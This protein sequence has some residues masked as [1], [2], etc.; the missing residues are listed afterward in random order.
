PSP[1]GSVRVVPARTATSRSPS[2][3]CSPPE[4]E[5]ARLRTDPTA[6]AA[7]R[8]ARYAR[9]PRPRSSGLVSAELSAFTERRCS[10]PSN[11][12]SSGDFRW[13]QTGTSSWRLTQR[14]RHHLRSVAASYL[15]ESRHRSP[16]LPLLEMEPNYWRTAIALQQPRRWPRVR[17]V[18]V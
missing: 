5:V 1:V 2:A 11:A 17:S 18:V 15:Y 9:L 16:Q 4:P 12:P 6:G 3:I 8:P 10:R 13:R 14:D 7:T